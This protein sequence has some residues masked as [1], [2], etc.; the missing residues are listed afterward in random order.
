MN[1]YLGLMLFYLNT[2]APAITGPHHSLARRQSQPAYTTR[3]A[4]ADSL[5][6][7]AV[8]DSEYVDTIFLGLNKN[9]Y[10]E[11]KGVEPLSAD[12]GGD[13][14]NILIAV[15]ENSNIVKLKALRKG[16]ADANMIV[17][18]KDTVL[19]Y[20]IRYAD[21]PRKN[22]YEYEI[23]AIR[24]KI[25]A[26]RAVR[27]PLTQAKRSVS[28]VV[29]ATEKLTADSPTNTGAVS[30]SPTPA[31]PAAPLTSKVSPAKD[32]GTSRKIAVGAVAVNNTILD[33]LRSQKVN[34][35]IGAISDGLRA[36]LDRLYRDSQRRVYYAITVE[37]RDNTALIVDYIGFQVYNKFT[38]YRSPIMLSHVSAAANPVSIPAHSARAFVFGTAPVAM[39]PE[40]ILMITL[41]E[42]NKEGAR[43]IAIRLTPTD[44][45]RAADWKED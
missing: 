2:V 43:E 39:L 34:V 13:K 5:P 18:C 24:Q 31:Q 14:Q 30:S 44:L 6:A 15:Q 4:S 22:Y 45:T 9:S 27:T 17:V 38:R 11:V 26:E 29:P 35:Q 20:L 21:N 7:R 40:E 37:N 19:Q 42:P 41:A 1:N 16:F 32:T 25:V 10:V 23:A 12:V 3:N 36:T 28:V 8:A 33:R